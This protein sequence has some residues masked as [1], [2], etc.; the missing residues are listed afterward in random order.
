ME[1]RVKGCFLLMVLFLLL[2]P[3]EVQPLQSRPSVSFEVTRVVWGED[4]DNPTKA[5]PGSTEVPL[6]VEV[7]NLSPNETIKGVKAVLLLE[8]SPFTDV[9]GNSNAT[10]TGQPEISEVLSPTDEILPKGFF[11]LTFTLN[12]DED[13]L[14][15][16]YSC[17]MILEYSVNCSGIY[18]EGEPQ[19]LTVEII[20]S[21]IESTISCSISPQT[22]E[23][24]EVIEVSGSISPAL[25]NVTVTL[26]YEGPDGS[27]YTRNVRTDVEGSF[28]DSFQPKVEGSWSVNA[29]WP[30]DE[31]HEGSWVSA[32]F[33][34][35]FP[36]SIDIVTS[37]NR[38]TGGLDNDFNIT[39]LN[40]GGVP[41]ST[42]EATLTMPSP[43]IVHGDNSWSFE[44][45]EP[46]GSITIPVKVYAP[47]GSIGSTYSGSLT[48]NYRDDYGE[49]HGE[50][51]PIG[52]IIV[53]RIELVV[54]GKEVAPQPVK[55]GSKVSITATLLNK[56]N[57]AARYVNASIVPNSLLDLTSESASYIGEVE[58]N[59]PAP[60]TLTAYV[61]GDA[62]EGAFPIKINITYRD[63]QYR[64]HSF[65]VTVYITVE[66]PP[67]GGAD[68]GVEGSLTGSLLEVG[69]ILLTL[70]GASAALVILYRRRLSTLSRSP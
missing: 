36:V 14:P 66:K 28:R 59:S 34:V 62:E 52:L 3:V 9:Y 24:G 30:G 45:L 18:L 51:Y 4:P 41:V 37:N 20:L 7:Q 67:Q 27:V 39:I 38:L 2:V 5:Y 26:T 21:K 35:R 49:S 54:Y 61:R 56:G 68:S 22:V 53:G 50:S 17:E 23:R 13:A 44:Y 10:A 55:P 11:T 12:V 43:L 46:G 29:S 47:E 1:G 60:F 42:I 63:D 48:L 33:E 64:D 31:K 32:S 69:V 19:T 25:E 65:N 6:T 16:T 15:G 40:T 8:N 57:V 70:A 58:E